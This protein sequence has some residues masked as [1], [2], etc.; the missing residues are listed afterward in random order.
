MTRHS[1]IKSYLPSRFSFEQLRVVKL[2]YSSRPWRIVTPEG[3]EL[4]QWEEYPGGGLPPYQG[5]LCFDRK[6]DAVA[7]LLK[8]QAE[9]AA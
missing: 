9:S 6:R 4:W 5:P 8:L 1:P 3:Q 2:D 7:A